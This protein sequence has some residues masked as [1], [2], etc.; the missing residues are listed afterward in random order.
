M[1]W[2]R[3]RRASCP[4]VP[5]N[6]VDGGSAPQVIAA[7]RLRIMAGVDPAITRL[8]KL[9]RRKGESIALSAVKDILD[10]A[11]LK[12]PEKVD[13]AVAPERVHLTVKLR[14]TA[15]V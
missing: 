15:C 4:C 10:R 2:S 9:L 5:L 13:V 8:M 12:A 1:I 7:A 11:G 3:T 6:A 14:C